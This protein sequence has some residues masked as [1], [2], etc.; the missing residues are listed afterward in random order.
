MSGFKFKQFTVIQEKSALKVGTDAVL[1][2]AAMTLPGGGGELLDI[3]TGTGVIAL[4][5]AQRMSMQDKVHAEQG[6]HITGID[7]DNPSAEEASVNFAASPWAEHLESVNMSL[8]RYSE[9]SGK[10]TVFSAI[11][12]NPPFYDNSL[13]NPDCRK[14]A[15][16]HTDS[17]SLEEILS[18]AAYHLQRASGKSTGGILSLILPAEKETRL[19][20][21]AASFGLFPFRILRIKTVPTKKP[22]RI[23]AEFR[24]ADRKP[25]ST[26]SMEDILTLQDGTG[27]SEEYQKLTEDFYL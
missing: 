17:L 27:R 7:I 2:G 18:F 9:E 23:I 11:F 26:G 3:G 5:A 19:I 1:L 24:P 22:R 8:G 20:R 15:A 16:R 4:M 14:S 13:R 10:D 6:W 12:S 25:D 21:K